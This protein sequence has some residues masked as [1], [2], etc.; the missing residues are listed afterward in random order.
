MEYPYFKAYPTDWEVVMRSA[1]IPSARRGNLYR[2]IFFA[3]QEGGLDLDDQDYEPRMRMLAQ[4][5]GL[6]YCRFKIYLDDY[7]KISR[8]DDLG[9]WLPRFLLVQLEN[10]LA[11][12]L[13]K[14]KKATPENGNGAN[15][16]DFQ[17]NH[18]GNGKTDTSRPEAI[19]Q[20]TQSSPETELEQLQ[21]NPG[22]ESEQ[23]QNRKTDLSPLNSMPSFNKNM[24]INKNNNRTIV[25]A[26]IETAT[27]TP[28]EPDFPPLELSANDPAET[29]AVKA[30]EKASG[31]QT[32]IPEQEYLA[33]EIPA[34]EA[35][36]F[37]EFVRGW[38]VNYGC[39]GMAKIV[40]SYKEQRENDKR[41]ASTAIRIDNTNDRR[42][43]NEYLARVAARPDGAIL[44]EGKRVSAPVSSG[45]ASGN[46]GDVVRSTPPSLRAKGLGAIISARS[47]NQ[48]PANDESNDDAGRV[49][50]RE[51]EA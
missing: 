29:P 6:P 26:E 21:N 18:K 39:K 42:I 41:R 49:A 10:A 43:I 11:V 46:R 8:Q 19:P 28:F 23:S 27:A 38:K 45:T 33:A 5:F 44:D 37:G 48:T 47:R 14:Q 16:S 22:T 3:W 1:G 7:K 2:L 50:V 31:R 36:A 13:A 51:S 9:R 30:F 34:N 15:I 24:N 35:E 17:N 4:A 12:T 40:K 32:S 20:Q 25:V